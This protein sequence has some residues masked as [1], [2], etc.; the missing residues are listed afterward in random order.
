[1]I[2]TCG[3]KFGNAFGGS[4]NSSKLKML[5]EEGASVQAKL[6]IWTVFNGGFN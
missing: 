4:N 5:L 3:I 1:M 2:F 6:W